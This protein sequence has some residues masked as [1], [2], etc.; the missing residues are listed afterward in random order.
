M[1][2]AQLTGCLEMI[3]LQKHNYVTYQREEGKIAWREAK[4]IWRK[5]GTIFTEKTIEF[6][7]GPPRPD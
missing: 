1:N 2:T 7:I 6:W 4:Q 3:F 5:T